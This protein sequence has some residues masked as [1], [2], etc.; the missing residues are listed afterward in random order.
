MA[1]L[2]GDHDRGQVR[3]GQLQR[4]VAELRRLQRLGRKPGR[5]L[6]RQRAHLGRRPGG[7]RAP[8]SASVGRPSEPLAQA[9]G[10]AGVRRRPAAA[11]CRR[12]AARRRPPVAGDRRRARPGRPRRSSSRAP[13]RRPRRVSSAMSAAAASVL[14]SPLVTATSSGRGR[15]RGQR[16]GQPHQLG[17]LAR[18]ADA[19]TRAR[20]G[21]AGSRKWSSSAAS[22]IERPDAAT[23]ERGDGGVA[24]V[25]GAAHPGEDDRRRHPR[26][27]A[28][29]AA[30]SVPARTSPVAARRM[31]S[32]W[33]AISARNLS[34][35]FPND[36]ISMPG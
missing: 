30:S 2:G 19:I 29:T 32:G 17:A 16:L 26:R 13:P 33:P 4:A 25:V 28:Q 8:S 3:A 35:N 23:G 31:A 11:P 6:Q 1:R 7:S 21:A 34:G 20:A 22:T 36:F 27:S 5:L 9:V 15:S 12:A 18:L 24:G 14:P 10:R